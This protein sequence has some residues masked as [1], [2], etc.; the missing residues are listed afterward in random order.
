MNIELYNAVKAAIQNGESI[1]D[2]MSTANIAKKN[3]EAEKPKTPIAD[4]IVNPQ[5]ICSCLDAIDQDGLKDS[6]VPI[7][8]LVAGWMIKMGFAP[9]DLY[10]SVPEF[11]N[12]VQ[13]RMEVDLKAFKAAAKFVKAVKR[14][15]GEAETIKSIVDSINNDFKRMFGLD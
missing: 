2:I 4:E 13:E 6:S 1:D 15:D 11:I 10:S 14:N 12:K 5:N 3:I 9:D 7:A 8:R